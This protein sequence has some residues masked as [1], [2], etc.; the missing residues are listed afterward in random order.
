MDTDVTPEMT[1]MFGASLALC[2]SDIPFNG[3]IAGVYVGYVDGEYII[4][5][6]VE[7]MERS[8]INLAVAG[9]KDAINMVESSASEVSEMRCWRLSCSVMNISRS[10]VL[11]KRR[12][13]RLP[14]RK[15]T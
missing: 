12:S 15:K 6:T 9:T 3:P 1:G 5:P 2:V 13:C 7:E 10:C 14:A 8:R 4:N 11:S